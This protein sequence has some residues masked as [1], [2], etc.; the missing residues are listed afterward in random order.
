MIVPTLRVVTPLRTLRVLLLTRSVGGCMPTRSAGTIMRNTV[1]G[2]ELARDDRSHAPRGTPLWTLCVLLATRS[3]GG[4]MPTRSEG[5]IRMVSNREQAP[6]HFLCLPRRLNK[7][8][9]PA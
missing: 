8:E 5:T 4:C 2:R 1:R 3:V 9:K 7:P 6:S